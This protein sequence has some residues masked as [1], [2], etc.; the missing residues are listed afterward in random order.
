ME[1]TDNGEQE[2]IAETKCDFTE[3]VNALV[4]GEE[5]SEEFRLKAATIFEAT[6]T[7]KVNDEVKALQEAFEESLTEEV[8]KVQTELSEKVDDYL[9]YAAESWMKENS[10]R[11]STVSRLRWQVILQRTQ[12]SFL[13]AQLHSARREFSMLDGMAGEIDDMEVK[14]Q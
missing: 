12:R 1:E 9:S 4:A 7:A 6:V 10:L 3:D 14:T 5:L 11:L 13:R 2:E 8:E